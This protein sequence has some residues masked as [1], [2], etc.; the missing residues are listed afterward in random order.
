MRVEDINDNAPEFPSPAAALSFSE[1]A[2][3]G[4]R[5]LLDPALDRDTG[6]AGRVDQY[7]ITTGNQAGLFRLVR[8]G[9]Y[10][11][12]ETTGPLDRETQSAFLLNISAQDGGSPA[13]TGHVALTVTVLDINDNAPV[14]ERVE[15]TARV[16]EWAGAGTVVAQVGATDRDTGENARLSYYPGPAGSQADQ[17][18]VDLETGVVTTAVRPLVC[19]A[20]GC[21]VPLVVRDH[22]APM[23]E[24]H[25]SL[26]VVLIDAND[27]DPEISFRYFPD[28]S[29]QFATVEESAGPDSLVA[30]VTVKDRDQGKNGEVVLELA[31][32][33]AA[34]FRL[35]SRA[36]QGVHV[37]RVAGGLDR[38]TTRQYNLSLVARDRGAPPRTATAFLAVHVI[39]VNDHAPVFSEER[40][41][42]SLPESAP[43]GSF[44]S[45]PRAEDED[46]GVNS[47]LYYSLTAGNEL[48]WFSIH[49]GS[50]LVTT[51]LP[52][53]RETQV[54]NNKYDVIRVYGTPSLCCRRRFCWRSRR[55]T[56]GR[57]PGSPRQSCWCGCRTRTTARRSG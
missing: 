18:S 47:A 28:Q 53:D 57:A 15:Y 46:S 11:H 32:G 30:A 23:Q 4:T 33:G 27:H 9:A 48:G 6:P 42:A 16:G 8:D 22:G 7:T 35:D 14:F 49:H 19:P 31:G 38:E 54:H 17:F 55:G 10:L 56:A 12:L 20:G 39:D 37:V 51:R 50:G 5:A 34:K 25:T 2:V 43:P 36:G 3:A 13:L 21:R 24:A 29:A 44:V 1:S 45:A 52:L 26:K 41:T 40:Y